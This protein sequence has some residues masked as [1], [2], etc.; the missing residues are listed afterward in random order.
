VPL[1][2]GA[3]NI[4][5]N[6]TELKEHGSRPRPFKQRLAIALS[7]ARKSGADIPKPKGILHRLKREN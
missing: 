5:R 1:I 7:V 4:G 6:I 2:G 3:D